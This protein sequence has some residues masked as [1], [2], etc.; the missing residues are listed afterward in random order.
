MDRPLEALT[1]RAYILGD[2]D[3]DYAEAWHTMR[4]AERAGVAAANIQTA[5]RRGDLERAREL[6]A[7]AYVGQD[8]P[9]VFACHEDCALDA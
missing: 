4:R 7:N 2:E 9:Y 5:V 8:T 3:E 1:E 6:L